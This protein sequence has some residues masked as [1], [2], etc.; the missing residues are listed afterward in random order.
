MENK[1][2]LYDADD[3]KIGETFS[4]RARQLVSRQRAEWV[5]ES[6]GAIRFFPDS[7]EW[8]TEDEPK[9][10]EPKG[11]YLLAE[12]RL[13]E[14]RRFLWHTIGFLPGYMLFALFAEIMNSGYR[15][16]IASFYFMFFNFGVWT[17]LYVIHAYYYY[18]R[19]VEGYVYY[20]SS[21]RERK[22]RKLAEEVD[23]LKRMGY[24]DKA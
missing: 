9:T 8:E 1:V 6:R 5:D 10:E 3:V 22:A 20:S 14:R 23:R 15:N 7:E 24:A 11:I 18:K 21:K 16:N 4:R 19:H 13:R 12:K 17:C 2:L